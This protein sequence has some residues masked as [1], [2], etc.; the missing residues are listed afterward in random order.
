MSVLCVIL[1]IIM[2]IG[3]VSCFFTPI[4]TMLSAGYLI[5]IL[6]L[7]FGIFGI[8]KAITDKGG[9]LDWI[10]SILAIIVGIVA[11][12]RP[13]GTLVLD[14]VL[15]YLVAAFFLVEGIAQIVM[16]FRSRPVNSS[17]GLN[18][19]AG[20]LCMLVGICAIASPMFAAVTVG[21]LIAFFF[22]GMG[23]SLV[24]LGTASGE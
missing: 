7:V 9:V 11:V 21:I 24:A 2:I 6:L 23:I 5:G 17:W 19:V 1:G 14:G 4:A 20:I 18:L 22:I 13:G 12:V 15:L 10:L 8:V 3:G 16:A